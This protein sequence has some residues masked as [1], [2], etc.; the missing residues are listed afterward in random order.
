MNIMFVI[1]LVSLTLQFVTTAAMLVL[2]GAPRW[3]RVRWFG[4]IALTAGLYSTVDAI[5][6]LR[7]PGQD[8]TSWSLR[9]NLFF[10]TLHASAWL[11]YTRV[12]RSGRWSSLPRW[13]Q[14][15]VVGG[16]AVAA[17]ACLTGV[18]ASPERELL[19]VPSLDISYERNVLSPIGSALGVLPFFFLFLSAH[20][21]WQDRRRGVEGTTPVLIGF[22]LFLLAAIEEVL[23]AA[24]VVPFIF[25]GDVGYICVVVPVTLQ[26]LR[27]LRDDADQLDL[28]TDHLADEVQR[29]TLERDDARER[30][31]EQERLAALG[32]LAAGVGHEINNPLQFLRFTLEEL[33]ERAAEVKDADAQQMIEQSFEGV[34]RIRQVVEDLRTYVRPGLA[35]LAPLDLREVVRAALRVGAPQWQQGA[36]IVTD[37]GEVPPVAGHEGRLVQVVLNPLVNGV[38]SIAQLGDP[39]RTSL[40]VSTRTLPNG[41]AEIEVRD[42]GGGFSEDIMSR[43]GEPY[44]TTKSQYGGTGLGL[45]VS[46]GIVESHGGLMHFANAPGGGAIVRVQL[47]PLE[48]HQPL[49]PTAVSAIDAVSDASP[50]AAEPLPGGVVDGPDDRLLRV[51][52]VEDDAPALRAMQRGLRLEQVHVTGFTDARDALAWLGENEVDIVVTDLMMPIMSGWEFAAR[53]AV[54]HPALHDSLVVLTGGA[55]TPEAQAFVQ[56]TTALVLDKPITREA[57]AQALRERA[58][59]TGAR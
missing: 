44:V 35:E 1:A 26:L 56:Q 4:A 45:F 16:A 47:P 22:T 30:M 36:Q 29:R 49:A 38:Q 23:V 12:D 17:V 34:D 32:R 25:L 52:M 14:Q 20:G 10:G 27:R 37:F 48:R 50:V 33:R 28:L 57:L 53:L 31:I 19:Y 54:R 55:S 3:R 7:A 13:V 46:R 43:L 51:L 58:G 21:V 41:W 39:A 9:F 40:F 24:D 15:L 11:V 2:G 5:A 8:D 59:R 6:A 18:V 42:Q